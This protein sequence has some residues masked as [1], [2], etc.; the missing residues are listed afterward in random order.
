MSSCCCCDQ[1]ATCCDAVN[2]SRPI[3]FSSFI[4]LR[5]AITCATGVTPQHNTAERQHHHSVA[6][7][8][9]VSV[10]VCGQRKLFEELM[11]QP[12]HQVPLSCCDTDSNNAIMSRVCWLHCAFASSSPVAHL[13][14]I[15]VLW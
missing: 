11:R 5:S 8:G 1:L 9:L 13:Q 6:D 12:E 15:A 10:C 3:A 14:G 7:T 4:N 2:V